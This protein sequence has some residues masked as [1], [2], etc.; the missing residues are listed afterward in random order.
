MIPLLMLCLSGSLS[1]DIALLLGS[2]ARHECYIPRAPKPIK[3]LGSCLAPLGS[4]TVVA[5]R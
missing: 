5:Q 1:R 2:R 4:A 3:P